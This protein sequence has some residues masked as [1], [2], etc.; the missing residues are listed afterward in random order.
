MNKI[1]VASRDNVWSRLFFKNLSSSIRGASFEWVKNDGELAF[2]LDKKPSWVFFFHWSSK[3]SSMVFENH[4]CVVVHTSN[5]PEGRGGSPIQNQI[6]EGILSSKVNLIEM[7]E[8][9]D[10]GDIYLSK[11][12][13]LQGTATDIWL[14]I[15]DQAAKLAETCVK[16]D[17]VPKPQNSPL[18]PPYRRIKNNNVLFNLEEILDVHKEIQMVDAPGYPD[19]FI[20]I[21]KYTIQFSRSKLINGNEILCDA[22]ITCE[23]K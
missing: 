19:A 12:V 20:K 18:N 8:G 7:V 21:G 15:A 11:D 10:E 3:V 17:L 22:R 5:L 14:M 13:T 2:A 4:R 16:K 9:F 23:E 1:I 6:R